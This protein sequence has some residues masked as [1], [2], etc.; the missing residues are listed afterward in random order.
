MYFNYANGRVYHSFI[1]SQRTLLLQ[2]ITAYL[3][4]SNQIL[5]YKKDVTLTP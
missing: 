5:K 2:Q 3:N 4:I 1:E